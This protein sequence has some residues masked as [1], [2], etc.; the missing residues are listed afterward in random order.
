MSYAI[1]ILL[2]V[3]TIVLCVR[4]GFERRTF[5]TAVACVNAT[6]YVLFAVL[7][8]S[9]L[10]ILVESAWSLVFMALALV[11]F[12][13]SPLLIA[14]VIASHGAFD[15]LHSHVVSDAGVPAWWPSFCMTYDVTAGLLL[16]L[17][18]QQTK[19]GFRR[20]AAAAVALA[21]VRDGVSARPLSQRA[22]R[23]W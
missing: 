21:I 12:R 4:A 13:R 16:L 20:G 23:S 5:F 11:G 22:A 10:V 17:L 14:L 9:G 15:L 3:V 18:T 19:T 1:G 8:G 7:D 2:A 6:Y